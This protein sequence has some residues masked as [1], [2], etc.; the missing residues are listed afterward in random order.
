M[1][2]DGL[3]LRCNGCL[4]NRWMDV[5]CLGYC[6]MTPALAWLTLTAATGLVLAV[7]NPRTA[8]IAFAL[9]LP[10]TY[11]AAHM[12][13]GMPADSAPQG[14]WQVH[15]ARIDKDV[16]IYALLSRD[17]SEPR[18]YR[19]PY[20]VHAANDLQQALD[21]QFGGNGSGIGAIVGEDGS[22]AFHADPVTGTDDKP[23]ETPLINGEVGG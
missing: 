18:F 12:P 23:A 16:A 5:C 22:A 15:G 17:G 1:S 11:Y 7:R 13:L 4:H 21:A 10:L 14:R 9:S 3:E 19:L 8:A 20:T 2:G 6:Q